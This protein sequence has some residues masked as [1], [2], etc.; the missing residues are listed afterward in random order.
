MVGDGDAMRVA[1]Q[2][3]E[4]S[5]WSA[6]GRL[7][8]DHPIFIGGLVTQSLE[9]YGLREWFQLAVKLESAI[10]KGAAQPSQEAFSEA[11]TEQAHREKEA[12]FFAA[13]PA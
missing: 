9:T 6:E 10:A 4:Y 12:G 2:I 3:L 7:D 5:A 13:D 11:M 1:S 8:V